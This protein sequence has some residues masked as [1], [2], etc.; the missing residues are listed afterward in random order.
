MTREN[1]EETE[2]TPAEVTE[3]CKS[4]DIGVTDLRFTDL[5][6][7]LQHR[8][9]M[10]AADLAMIRQVPGLPDGVLAALEGGDEFLMR[11]GVFT[12]DVIETWLDYKANDVD[13][14]RLMPHPIE[15]FEHFDA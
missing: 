5:P 14:L 11:E 10:S 2:V 3:F 15:F 7:T 1:T 9:E 6:G 8:S 12:D 4:N 13:D